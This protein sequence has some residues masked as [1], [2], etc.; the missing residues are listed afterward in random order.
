MLRDLNVGEVPEDA[1]LGRRRDRAQLP[2]SPESFLDRRQSPRVFTQIKGGSLPV[3]A[4]DQQPLIP[5]PF[6]Q[7]ARSPEQGLRRV[8]VV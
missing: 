6:E 2:A 5:E 1:G 4:F 8:R 3:E 7:L